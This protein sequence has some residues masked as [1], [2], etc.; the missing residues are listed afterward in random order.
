MHAEYW[1]HQVNRIGRIVKMRRTKLNYWY[2]VI[3]R[4][5]RVISDPLQ[6]RQIAFRA[7]ISAFRTEN[8]RP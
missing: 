3:G 6:M 7:C 5:N 4:L 8:Y 1:L 2:N